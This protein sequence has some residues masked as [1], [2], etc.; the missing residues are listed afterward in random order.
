MLKGWYADDFFKNNNAD[1][2]R[3]PAFSCYTTIHI[4]R[5]NHLV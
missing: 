1:P 4:K 3:N 2:R 5:N